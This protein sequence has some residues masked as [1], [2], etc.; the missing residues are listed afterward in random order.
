[1]ETLG[2]SV[3]SSVP[4][5]LYGVGDGSI[6]A[7]DWTVA[8][9]RALGITVP[10]LYGRFQCVLAGHDHDARLHPTTTGF[11]VY[12][13]EGLGRGV[14]LAEIRAFIG[15]GGE[16]HISKLEAARWSERLDYEASLRPAIPLDV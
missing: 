13:C 14:G 3:P 11:W 10:P 9:A 16:R 2:P 12:R 7:T 4:G 15:Y 5:R 6:E 8:R 1:L